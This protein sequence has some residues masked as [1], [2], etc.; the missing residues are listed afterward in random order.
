MR[1]RINII[2]YALTLGL[3][4]VLLCIG[5]AGHR[6]YESR[7]K[8]TGLE[9][10]LADSSTK[11]F[12]TAAEIRGIIDKEYGGYTNVPMGCISL[13]RI[14]RILAAEGILERHEAYFT[15]DGTLHI[16]ASQCTPVMKVSGEKGEWYLCRGGRCFRVKHD[17]CRDI[18]VMRGS[19]P[20]NDAA[21]I[22]E[23][24]CLGETIYDGAFPG[25]AIESLGCNSKG[26]ISLRRSDRPEEFILGRATSLENKLQR[27]EKYI[28]MM[29]KETSSGLQYKSVNLK[30]DGQIIC[31]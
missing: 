15:P 8:C 14:E 4:T 5:I 17:W 26:D 22:R 11:Q 25:G 24:A 31:K 16:E 9:V 2:L 23:A 28:R 27:M 10:E 1:K 13:H 21:W 7:H 12:I 6:R 3:A 29:Q 20:E 30:Y 18:P 19:M